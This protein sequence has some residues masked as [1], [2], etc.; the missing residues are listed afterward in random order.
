MSHWHYSSSYPHAGG[1]LSHSRQSQSLCCGLV[2]GFRSRS[3][4]NPPGIRGFDSVPVPVQRCFQG[5]SVRG[6]FEEDLVSQS[7]RGRSRL[8]PLSDPS[9]LNPNP[10]LRQKF[11]PVCCA[12]GT[13]EPTKSKTSKNPGLTLKL[14]PSHP[15]GSLRQPWL[16]FSPRLSGFVV[17]QGKIT[18]ICG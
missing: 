18:A 13:F 9:F 16:R 14:R 17:L 10:P 8:D 11:T 1:V 5:C 4:S 7:R 3:W 15:A 12:A 2:L 6:G